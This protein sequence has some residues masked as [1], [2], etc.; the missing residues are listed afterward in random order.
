MPN[1]NKRRGKPKI[2]AQAA[3]DKIAMRHKS[4]RGK[5]PWEMIRDD[6]VTL[7]QLM[8]NHQAQ[9]SPQ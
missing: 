9:G 1:S 3:V 7:R 2:S 5:S 4:L 8:D 6:I